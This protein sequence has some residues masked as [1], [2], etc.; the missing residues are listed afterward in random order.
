MNAG[1]ADSLYPN[2]KPF[3]VDE[4]RQH[5]GLHAFH[6]ISPSP[7]IN[8]KFKNQKHDP[9]NGNDFIRKAFDANE[10]RRR[11]HFK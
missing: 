8:M 11:K 7:K 6:G 9:V 2:F 5:V 10:D 4:I 1:Q 3:A